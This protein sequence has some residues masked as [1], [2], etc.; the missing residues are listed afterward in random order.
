MQYIIKRNIN[1]LKK[2]NIIKFCFNIKFNKNKNGF[3]NFDINNQEIIID[4]L[5]NKINKEYKD[6]Y[7]L[8]SKYFF[9][10]IKELYFIEYENDLVI[11]KISRKDL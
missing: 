11:F 1:L 6:S 10:N 9:D 8:V 2:D 5:L 7:M 4:N 3:K